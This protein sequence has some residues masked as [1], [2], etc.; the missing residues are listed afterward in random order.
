VSIALA[1][2]FKTTDGKQY[3]DAT[4]THVEPDG[5]VV[6]T[7][8]GISKIYFQELPQEVQQR[9]NYD[10]QRAANYSAQ[11]NA[12]LEQAQKQQAASTQEIQQ[13]A[14]ATQK[15]LQNV[16]KQQALQILQQQYN[17]LQSREND[18]QARL[19]QATQPG[20]TH[21]EVRGRRTYTIHDRN[22]LGDEIGPL[23]TQLKAV[24]REKHEVE[25]RFNEWK[26]NSDR[27]EPYRIHGSLTLPACSL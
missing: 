26:K 8:S 13:Q 9:F 23:Q 12:A 1:D 19:D 7:K 18:L 20:P 10:P 25:Q 11:Q 3:K 16:G 15:A 6:K 22:P 4:V 27:Q 5:I 2:D 24:R 14:D 21:Q 17:H